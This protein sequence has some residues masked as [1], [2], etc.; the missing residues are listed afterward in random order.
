MWEFVDK[1]VYINLDH[2]EDRRKLMT[3]LFETGGIPPEKVERFSAI[4]HPVGIVGCAMSHI[5]I[6]KR[7]KQ[8]GWKSVLIFEDD[9]QWIDF[10]QNYKKLE[11][12][13]KQPYDV[14][15]IGGCYLETTPPKVH[16]AVCTNAYI[17]KSHYYDTL[18]E[19]FE[20]GL[21]K[22]LDKNPPRIWA[23][24]EKS[25]KDYYDR[26]NVDTE[27]GI[28]IY[29]FKLQLKDNWVGVMPA[30]CDQAPTYSDI[31]NT[32]VVHQDFDDTHLRTIF[33]PYV[34]DLIVQGKL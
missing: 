28:D 11:E 29:W 25:T 23:K 27:H 22:K 6:L 21:R 31:Y 24:T 33:A 26:V 14:C 32:V 2:R 4:R 18:L 20:S 3:K 13:V 1:V 15:M 8:Q 16:M 17:V 19:N 7:A 34:K 30:M 5:G 10:E 9:M 12:L